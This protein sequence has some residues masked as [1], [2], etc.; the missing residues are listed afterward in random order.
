[1]LAPARQHGALREWE[2][3]VEGTNCGIAQP[4]G[5]GQKFVQYWSCKPRE[6]RRTVDRDIQ[7]SVGQPACVDKEDIALSSMSCGPRSY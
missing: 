3:C 6:R 1:M 2:T 5:K 7:N 4:G